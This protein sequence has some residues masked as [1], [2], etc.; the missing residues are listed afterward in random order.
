M[1]RKKARS[2]SST[3]SRPRPTSDG[4]PSRL[5]GPARREQA[6]RDAGLGSLEVG[7][8]GY[9]VAYALAADNLRVGRNVIADSVSPWMLTRDAWRDVGLAA[10]ARVLEVE[11]VCSDAAAH[12]RRVETRTPDSPVSSCRTGRW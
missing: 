9:R 5:L 10:N 12:R 6:I 4:H 3:R 7:G 2:P 11:V 1:G 8:A